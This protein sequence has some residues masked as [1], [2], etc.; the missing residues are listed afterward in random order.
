MQQV[1]SY[2]DIQNNESKIVGLDLL[3]RPNDFVMHFERYAASIVSTIAYGRRIPSSSDPI[4]TEV[5]AVMHVAA[6]LNVPGKSFPMLMETFPILA[7]FPNWMAPWKKGLGGRSRGFDFFYALAKEANESSTNDN[8]SRQIF[9]LAEKYQ[10]HTREISS[11]SGNLFGAGSDTSA[12]TLITFVLACVMFP[13]AVKKAQEELDRVV[14]ST[15]SPH[16]D[17]FPNL[18]YLDAF[19]KEIFRWRSVA[20][21]GGQPHAP[22]QDDSY[23]GW[24]IPKYTWVQGNL[25]YLQLLATDF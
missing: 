15:R 12:S 25:W 2:R 10:L 8:F 3:N 20:I 5:I 21:I 7:K 19:V 23:N 6:D 17:D 11:I 9:E 1:R 24:F 14:G 4:I 16:F 13:D 18:P 22:I